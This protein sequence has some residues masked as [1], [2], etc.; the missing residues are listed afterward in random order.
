MNTKKP[1]IGVVVP[2]NVK[3]K[4]EDLASAQQ[5]KSTAKV[6]AS[7]IVREAIQ[8]YFNKRNIDILVSVDRGGDRI[9][10]D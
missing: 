1:T 6:Y 7:D 2:Q 8:E 4:L 5:E 9:K 3:D 10:R